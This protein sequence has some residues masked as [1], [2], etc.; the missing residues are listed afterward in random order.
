MT[1]LLILFFKS[2]SLISFF[3]I[4]TAGKSP[5]IIPTESMDYFQSS[6]DF[7]T[8]SVLLG[9]LNISADREDLSQSQTSGVYKEQ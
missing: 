5:N 8:L 4:I 3:I 1:M 9:C 6:L 7:V 2:I